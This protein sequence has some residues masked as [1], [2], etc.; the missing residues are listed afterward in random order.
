M[1][2]AEAGEEFGD[3]R[4]NV[5]GKWLDTILYEIPLLVL[6]S[7]CYF[8]FANTDWDYDG[9]EENAY[10]YPNRLATSITNASTAT[11]RANS[12]SKTVAST[13][14]SELAGDEAIIPKTSSS[15]A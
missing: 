9:Q 10:D 1:C 6:V 12:S 3:V 4:I 5:K 14:N 8:K 11:K 2:Q 15:A 13:P 7:E